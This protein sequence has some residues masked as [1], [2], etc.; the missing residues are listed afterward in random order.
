MCIKLSHFR[1]GITLTF[2]GENFEVVEQPLFI[3][4][5]P[6]ISSLKVMYSLI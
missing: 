5:D 2:T 3:Y 1:G 6:D 4:T